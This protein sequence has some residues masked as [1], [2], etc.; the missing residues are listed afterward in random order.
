MSSK[1]WRH[2]IQEVDSEVYKT[3]KHGI[4]GGFDEEKFGNRIGFGNLKG[5][6]P[7]LI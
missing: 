1:E 5:C 4:T 3:L 7:L 6:D 2:Q